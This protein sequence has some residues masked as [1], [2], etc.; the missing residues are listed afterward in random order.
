M[1][2]QLKPLLEYSPILF[3]F[4]G[5]LVDTEKQHFQ[6]YKQTVESFSLSFNWDYASF[7]PIAH[8]SGVAIRQSLFEAYPELFQKIT[9]EEFYAKKSARYCELIEEGLTRFMPGAEV[10]IRRLLEENHSFAVVTNS[11]RR[12]IDLVKNN[13]PLLKK[14]PH[15][16]VREDYNNPKPAPDG[17]LKA[18]EFFG[19]KSTPIGFEDTKKGIV[20]L[21]AAGVL[22][23]LV[24]D[25]NHPQREHISGDITFYSSLTHLLQ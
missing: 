10:L 6:A 16:F 12:Q 23:V 15:W 5:L 18:L 20:S 22:P 4:D 8:I 13:L 17:Y 24:C 7:M 9:W 11:T 14:V 19:K 25:E 21:S 1:H 3:D 2:K